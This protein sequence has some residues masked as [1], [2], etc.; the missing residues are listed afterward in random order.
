MSKVFTQQDLKDL[1]CQDPEC[2]HSS[3]T[4]DELFMHCGLHEEAA[5]H[6]SYSNGIVSVY[7]EQCKQVVA[8][9]EVANQPQSQA[10]LQ[11]SS[12]WDV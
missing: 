5:M 7:C 2:D 1:K 10:D 9:F 3:D 8:Q 11:T 6:V 12:A 4:N